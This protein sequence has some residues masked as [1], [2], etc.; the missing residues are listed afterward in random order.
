LIRWCAAR[1]TRGRRESIPEVQRGVQV[2][3]LEWK[4]IPCVLSV[5]GISP[6]N[7]APHLSFFVGAA[8]VLPVGTFGVPQDLASAL[9][10]IRGLLAGEYVLGDALEEPSPRFLPDLSGFGTY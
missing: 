2:E 1:R 5:L 10:V 6:V 9:S 7:L 3:K 4:K 8:V